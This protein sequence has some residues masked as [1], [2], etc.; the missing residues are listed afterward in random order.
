MNILHVIRGAAAGAAYTTMTTF[1][2]DTYDLNET[3][4]RY[5]AGEQEYAA[6]RLVGDGRIEG[7]GETPHQ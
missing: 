1:L 3:T 5:A 4:D 7:K 2:A 6:V